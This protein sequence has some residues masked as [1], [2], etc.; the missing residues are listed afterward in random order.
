MT[1]ITADIGLEEGDGAGVA[2]SVM[3]KQRLHRF[4]VPRVEEARHLLGIGA[5]PTPVFSSC[6]QH[7]NPAQPPRYPSKCR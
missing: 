7:Q 3:P 1:E 5:G 2:V 4:L 6:T